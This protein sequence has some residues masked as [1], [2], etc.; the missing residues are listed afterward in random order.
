MSMESKTIY[1][2]DET[3]DDFAGTHIKT[4]PL[5]D[6]YRYM[7][8][9]HLWRLGAAVLYRMI[10]QPLVFLFIKLVYMQRFE[11]RDV[12][13][14]LKK[15]GAY[16]YANHTNGALD[17]FVPNLL[18]W[19]KRC[20]II[21]GPDAMSINGLNNILEMLGAIPLGS[22]RQQKL[23]M[24]S[25]VSGRVKQGALVTIYP[26]AHIWPYYTGIRPYPDASFTYPAHDKSPVYA[27]TNCYQ[28]RRFGR[29]PKV[30]SYV[31]GPFYPDLSLS[32]PERKQ[33]L[34]E[35]C[36]SAMCIRAEKFSTYQYIAYCKQ[37]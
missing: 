1:Y 12:L 7:K 29:F 33:K 6:D 36:H 14:S 11:N 17:A 4:K 18:C 25:C 27:L 13:R 15:S 9:S 21:V 30:V 5:R 32:I 16:I 26:E 8:L 19:R 28:R 3:T 35:Q 24:H 22:T 31:D 2:S 20:Y 23:E 34:R 10:A 37:S